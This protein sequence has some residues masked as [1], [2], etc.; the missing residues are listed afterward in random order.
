[1]FFKK[2]L[3][4]ILIFFYKKYKKICLGWSSGLVIDNVQT[5]FAMLPSDSGPVELTVMDL[6][7]P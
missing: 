6:K 7:V 1:M 2:T 5:G 3:Y 4:F